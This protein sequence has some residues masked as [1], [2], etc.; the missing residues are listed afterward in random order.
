MAKVGA[1]RVV[2]RSEQ[3]PGAQ[4]SSS[5]RPQPHAGAAPIRSELTVPPTHALLAG[6]LTALLLGDAT[7]TAAADP[8]PPP[9]P[10][11]LATYAFLAR[12]DDPVDAL[13]ASSVAAILGGVVLLTPTSALAAEARAALVSLAP[14]VVVLAGGTAALSSDVEDVVTAIPLAV[15]RIS[16]AGRVQT[17]AALAALPAELGA[18]RPVLTG[19][20]VVGDASLGGILAVDALTVQD[21]GRVAGLNADRLDDLDST[22]FLRSTDIADVLRPADVADVLRQSDV[23]SLTAT[24]L[25]EASTPSTF[26]GFGQPIVE[27]VEAAVVTADECG[28]GAT[29]HRYLVEA[30]TTAQFEPPVNTDFV[31]LQGLVGIDLGTTI[32]ATAD[33]GLTLAT[34]QAHASGVDQAAM[35]FRR[36]VDAVPPGDH[37]ATL[38]METVDSESSYSARAVHAV[39]T[40]TDLGY[41]CV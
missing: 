6:L 31:T 40:A 10:E 36:V 3:A 25:V 39:L 38:L 22:D 30:T 18:G 23:R 4:E 9:A 34:L 27:V 17:A 14:D 1:D 19:T 16:G 13:A 24:N 26:I 41:D 11:P 15:R 7:G 21:T 20:Q 37:T 28:G 32:P 2:L 33:E 12:A 29:R 8:L 5:L 35:A